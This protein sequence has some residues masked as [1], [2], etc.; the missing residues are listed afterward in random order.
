VTAGQEPNSI[1]VEL[2]ARFQKIRLKL[3]PFAQGPLRDVTQ[4]LDNLFVEWYPMVI[5]HGGIVDDNIHITEG[6][7][8]ITGIV[9]WR[10]AQIGPF[11]LHF[12]GLETIFGH[13][14]LCGLDFHPK[15]KELRRLF[16]STLEDIIGSEF[17]RFQKTVRLAR[18][19]GIFLATERGL[20]CGNAK[21]ML[22]TLSML[23][24]VLR[25]PE[26]GM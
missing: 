7:G 23:Y 19:I 20:A 2:L 26:G 18:K 25:N 10:E 3:P 17:K 14:R 1:Q 22:T 6:Y 16:W 4:Q 21:T 15:Q 9:D 8:G 5:N 12:W 13:P 11:G 24:S